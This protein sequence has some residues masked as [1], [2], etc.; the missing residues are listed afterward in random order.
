MKD[1]DRLRCGSGVEPVEH[2][3]MEV[4]IQ[5]QGAPKALH[6]GNGGALCVAYTLLFGGV[7]EPPEDDAQEHRQEVGTQ[8]GVEGELIAEGPVSR[9]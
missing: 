5:I 9:V 1:G 3:R 4:K 8:T 2:E 7:L 6:D